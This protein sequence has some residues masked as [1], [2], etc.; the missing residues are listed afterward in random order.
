MRFYTY[1]K[2]GAGVDQDVAADTIQRMIIDNNGD[3][4]IG[5]TDPGAKLH[6]NG[7][8]NIENIQLK[9]WTGTENNNNREIEGPTSGDFLIRANPSQVLHLGGQ[10]IVFSASS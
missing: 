3:V 8:A 9:K 5:T 10:D 4:G 1:S 2:G 7:D 6:V